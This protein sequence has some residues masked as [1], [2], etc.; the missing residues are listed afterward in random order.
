MRRVVVAAVLGLAVGGC[1]DFYDHTLIVHNEG[2]STA[3]VRIEWDGNVDIEEVGQG[4]DLIFYLGD[5]GAMV[6]ITRVSDEAL[7]FQQYLHGD[8]FD[9]SHGDIDVT[10][11]P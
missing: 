10:V 8:D 4:D 1:R 11:S 5:S 2:W 7:L 3:R 9:D 6:T